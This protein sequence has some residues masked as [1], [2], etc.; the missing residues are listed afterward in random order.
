VRYCFLPEE[1]TLLLRYFFVVHERACR[2][3]KKY[4]NSPCF[5]VG[6]QHSHLMAVRSVKQKSAECSLH[7]NRPQ[8]PLKYATSQKLPTIDLYS[9]IDSG[10]N[11]L[12]NL[13]L[14]SRP[15]WVVP[16][17][18]T[19][20][21]RLICHACHD[22]LYLVSSHMLSVW[23]TFVMMPLRWDLRCSDDSVGWSKVTCQATESVYFDIRTRKQRPA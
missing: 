10:W 18:R 16:L 4:L 2:V 21:L 14:V 3:G 1:L 6:I 11:K 7:E 22:D 13:F 17:R 20:T 19:C 15:V 8:L 5:A 23:G 9:D 12:Q